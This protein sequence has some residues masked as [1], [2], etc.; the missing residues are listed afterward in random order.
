MPR[1]LRSGRRRAAAR[2]GQAGS[3]T[4]ELALVAP[5]LIVLIFGVF[6]FAEWRHAANVAEAAAQEGARAARVEGGTAEAGKARAASFMAQL[7]PGRLTDTAISVSRTPEQV[8]VEVTG[9]VSATLF[10]LRLP[11]RARAVAPVERFVPID[12]QGPPP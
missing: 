9:R 12:T 6:Q 7:A 11:V 2:D 3:A 10:N 5:L 4:A 1:V 8:R